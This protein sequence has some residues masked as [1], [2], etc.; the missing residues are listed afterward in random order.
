MPSLVSTSVE[1]RVNSLLDVWVCLT[2][3]P[4]FPVKKWNV[5]RVLF[6]AVGPDYLK[7]KTQPRYLNFICRT[8]ELET[9]YE[10]HLMC[11]KSQTTFSGKS[12]ISDAEG[13][14]CNTMFA[15]RLPNAL[16]QSSMV[17]VLSKIYI[18]CDTSSTPTSK[19]N[20]STTLQM[21][22]VYSNNKD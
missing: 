15:S 19:V 22:M 11:F 6:V 9:F 1:F 20:I 5:L 4:G 21:K 17:S 3:P 2:E 8:T 14:K 12:E 13:K 16:F 10:Q 7:Q 18:N